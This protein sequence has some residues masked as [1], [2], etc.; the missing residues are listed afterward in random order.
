MK[1]SAL[2]AAG[3]ILFFSVAFSAYSLH[4]ETYPNRPIEMVITLPP[5]DNLDMTGRAIGAELSKVLKTPVIPVNKTGGAGLMGTDAVAKGKK[6]GYT[7][8]LANSNIIYAYATNPENVPY[9]VFQDLEPLCSVA[10]IAITLAVQAQSPWNTIKEFA[11]YA[12]QNPGNVRVSTTGVGGAGHFDF[13]VI[14]T[15]TKTPLIM[16]PYKGGSPAMTALLGGHAEAG[17][18]AS[19]LIAPHIKAGKLRA[20]LTSRKIPEFPS[21]PTLRDLGFARDMSST[22]FA[23]FVP[24]G[25]PESARK[26]L[27]AGLEK[28]IKSADVLNAMQNLGVLEDY[29][30]AGEFKKM[31]A[32][33]YG[34]IKDVFKSTE[35]PTK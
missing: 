25:V 8:L 30:P 35:P 19:G 1:H 13:E 29:K 11:D 28:C 5:G 24:S 10:S 16:V 32:E 15:E 26:V 7:I 6:D 23:F 31:M 21:I 14:R 3:F 22:W 12:K 27:I 18:L 20:L 34:M 4:A 9:N 33:E 2:F 17:I